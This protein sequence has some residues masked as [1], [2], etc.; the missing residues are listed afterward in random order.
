MWSDNETNRDFLNF[1]CV[2]DTAAEMIVQANGQPLSMGVSGGWGAGKS[3]MLKLISDS[4]EE[5]GDNRYLFV[6]FNAWLYQGYDDAR[7]AL[8]EV[9]AR[10]L[11]KHGEKSQKGLDKAK[12]LLDRV[13]WLRLAGLTV[14]SALSVAAGL[15]PVGLLG[16]VLSAGKDLADGKIEKEEVEAAEK[17]GKAVAAEAEKLITPSS[18]SSPPRQIQDL[19]KHFEETLREMNVTLVAFIDDLDRCLPSTAIA[20]LEAIRLFL[21]LPHT[22]FIIAADDR[23]IRQA[24]RVHFHGAD[25][26]DDLVTNYFDKLVQ[27]PLRV[28]PL[29]TQEVRAYLM[30]LFVENS[31]INSEKRES[32]R[33]QVCQRLSESWKGHRVDLRFVL[34]LMEDDCPETLRANLELADRLA[35]LMTT[36]KQIAGNP[37]LIKRFLNTLSIRLAIAQVQHVAVDEGALAKMLLFERCADEDAYSKL[38]SAINDGDEGKPAFLGDWEEKALAGEKIENL[39]SS[40]ES[41]FI[42][43]WL[44][45]PPAFAEMDLRPV[46]YVSREHMPIITAADQLSSEAAGILEA[47]LDLERTPSTVLVDQLRSLPRREIT[48]ITE[49]LMVRARQEQEWG[50]PPIL[51]GLLTI[52]D[53]ESE[54]ETTLVRFLESIPTARLRA[55]IVPALSDRKW[56][57]RALDKWSLDDE[58]PQPVKRAIDT[59]TREV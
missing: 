41:A 38:I 1:R 3:S 7:A 31:D 30:L 4:L 37:R 15:P 20:T 28:P 27:V 26:D 9:I 22:A 21:F 55:D 14:G 47:L 16:A 49:R 18:E 58:T 54:H 23:M 19:R 35:P 36:A 40:W 10:R 46:V 56:A 57:R 42:M 39:G 32:I 44:A 45:L 51:W 8:M 29:G 48:L 34:G 13:N 50:T 2:A 33:D 53:A 25:L 59:M 5:R 6:E 52:I 12:N 43:E 24:V 17:T 11:I